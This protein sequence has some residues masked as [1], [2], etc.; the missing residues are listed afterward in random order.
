MQLM[1]QGNQKIQR[2]DEAMAQEV[3]NQMQAIA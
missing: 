2:P 3:Q 1:S